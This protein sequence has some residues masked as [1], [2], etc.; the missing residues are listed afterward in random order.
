MHLE[1]LPQPARIDRDDNDEQGKGKKEMNSLKNFDDA[2][3]LASVQVVDIEHDA[4]HGQH[5][6]LLVGG[7]ACS[8]PLPVCANTARTTGLM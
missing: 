1:A 6:S 8:P 2:I 7:M 5:A 3:L 4:P